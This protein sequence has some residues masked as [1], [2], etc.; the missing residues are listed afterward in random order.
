MKIWLRWH[1]NVKLIESVEESLERTFL[2]LSHPWYR[3]FPEFL[4][5]FPSQEHSDSGDGYYHIVYHDMTHIVHIISLRRLTPEIK[6]LAVNFIA[7]SYMGKREEHIKTSLYYTPS[8]QL[9]SAQGDHCW[10][11]CIKHWFLSMIR[12]SFKFKC[13]GGKVTH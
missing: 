9:H 5:L 10:S 13:F 1:V 7:F 3:N 6:S 2:S 8:T 12:S 11:I 4:T